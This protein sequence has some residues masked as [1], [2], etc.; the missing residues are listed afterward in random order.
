[1]F[2]SAHI[3]TSASGDGG[4][5]QVRPQVRKGCSRPRSEGEVYKLVDLQNKLFP[6]CL[7]VPIHKMS[8]KNF[9]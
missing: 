7:A 4:I 3:H 5:P 2:D 8:P 6:A 1:M 9:T